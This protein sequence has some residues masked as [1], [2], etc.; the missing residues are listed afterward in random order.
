MAANSI[1]FMK[2]G[3]TSKIYQIS[4]FQRYFQTKYLYL[5]E[6][7]QKI[8]FAMTNPVIEVRKANSFQLFS[9]CQNTID[10]KREQV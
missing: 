7:I 10:L 5:I 4:E 8:Q 6:V 3:S 2:T 9:F 1:D